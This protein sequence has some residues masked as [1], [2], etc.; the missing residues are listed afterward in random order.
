MS[1]VIAVANQKG[2]V[3]KTTTVMNLGAG[4]AGEEKK[5]LMID[6]DPQASLTL[7]MGYREPDKLEYSVTDI[8]IR[9]V[10]DEDIPDELGIIHITEYLDLL[11]S[12]IDLS[13]IE[14]SM[15]NAMSRE[16]VLRS[17][18]EIVREKYDFILIDCMPSLGILT[19]N[20][21]ACA[22]SVLVPVQAAYL[23]VKGLQQLIRTI[24]TVK[25]RLNSNLEFEGI[26]FTMVDRRT[27]YAKSIVTNVNEVY[28]K[29]IPVFQI[30]IPISVKASEISMVAKTIYDY[31]PKGKAA[32]AYT[33]LTREVLRHGC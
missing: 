18:I 10:N 14:V 16:L 21:L 2:G 8:L 24:H 4:L 11:P 28:G 19:V 23:P 3:G 25:R 15:V 1:K 5:V 9:E 33:E 12:N 22:D 30:E 7:S 6:L 31:D 32:N 26:L 17:Y 29:S 13:A 20:A 27:L